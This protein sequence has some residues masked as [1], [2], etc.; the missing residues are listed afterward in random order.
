MDTT[1]AATV[2]PSRMA[3]A[4]HNGS[5]WYSISPACGYGVKFNIMTP[6]DVSPKFSD[7][8]TS[9][10]CKLEPPKCCRVRYFIYFGIKSGVKSFLFRLYEE[11]KGHPLKSF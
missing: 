7:G 11:F 4:A 1:G 6:S 3:A 8:I 2:P 10:R 9:K 5:N